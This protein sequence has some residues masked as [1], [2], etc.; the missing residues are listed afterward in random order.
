MSKESEMSKRD[1][2]LLSR[3]TEEFEWNDWAIKIPFIQWP[4]DWMVK[5]V[6]PFSTGIIRYWIKRTD[7]DGFVSVYLDCYDMAGS[8]GSPYW[9]IYPYEGDCYRCGINKIDELLDAISF[10]LEEI[11]A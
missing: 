11:K 5:A 4:S 7:S 6:P 1:I 9:E 3:V 10:S 2:Y 8:C